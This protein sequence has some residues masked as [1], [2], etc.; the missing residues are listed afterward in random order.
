MVKVSAANEW[1]YTDSQGIVAWTDLVD[2]C[3]CLFVFILSHQP[4]QLVIGVL[5]TTPDSQPL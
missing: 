4:P 5:P 3:I 1:K 2:R